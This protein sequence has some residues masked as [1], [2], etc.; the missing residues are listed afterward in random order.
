MTRTEQRTQKLIDLLGS[1]GDLVTDRSRNEAAEV[2]RAARALTSLLK[3]KPS[4][5][6][7]TPKAQAVRSRTPATTASRSRTAR[8][9]TRTVRAR[10]TG[11]V[12]KDGRSISEVR[13]AAAHKAWETKRQKARSR[14]R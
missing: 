2:K 13:R 9:A 11:S 8:K 7:S 12:T 1:V 10:G 3:R 4:R 5:A 6:S 14:Q